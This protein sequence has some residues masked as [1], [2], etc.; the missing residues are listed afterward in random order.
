MRK[1]YRR[2]EDEKTERRINNS[3]EMRKMTKLE[4]EREREEKGKGR[5]RSCERRE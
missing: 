3:K 5:K 1:N 2:E 4:E